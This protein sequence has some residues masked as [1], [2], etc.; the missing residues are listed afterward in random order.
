MKILSLYFIS[1]FLIG[2]INNMCGQ[3]VIEIEN[4]VFSKI[5]LDEINKVK[6]IEEE[7]PIAAIQILEDMLNKNIKPFEEYEIFSWRLPYLYAEQKE[8]NKFLDLLVKAQKK[9]YFFPFQTGNRPY[10]EFLPEIEDKNRLQTLLEKNEKLKQNFEPELKVEY[11][12]ST[13]VNYSP[14]NKYPLILII[15]GGWGSHV[16]SKQNWHS[17]KIQSQYIVAYIQGSVIS[18]SYL[19]SF[20]REIGLNNIQIAYNQIKQNYSVDT[21][22]IVLGGQSAGGYRSVLIALDNLIPATGLI[23]AF[24]VKPREL[25]VSKVM[26]MALRGVR[27]AFICGENDWGLK[28]QKEM[29][30]IFDKL[31]VVNRIVIFPQIGH[32][33]PPQFTEQVHQS[34]DFIWNN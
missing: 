30:V 34:L 10:P 16:S 11:F 20:N 18:G 32:E 17:D 26:D 8:Y 4:Q 15:H 29:A 1:L 28:G 7:N 22:K 21:T 31:G 12:V 2:I 6:E 5:Y 23:L 19:R 33:F 13:P 27:A 9:E 3:G 25:E 14:G 24:P